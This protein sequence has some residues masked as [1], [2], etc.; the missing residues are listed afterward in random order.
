[1]KRHIPSCN[2]IFGLA[3][4]GLLLALPTRVSSWF[5]GLPWV[6]EAETILL[7]II[8]PFLLI[9]GWRFLAMRLPIILLSLLLLIKVMM[10]LTNPNSGWKIKVHPNLTQEQVKVG[11]F[12]PFEL[13]GSWVRTYATFWNENTSGILKMPW[14]EKLD[15]PLDWA[16][17]KN[18]NKCGSPPLACFNAL[19]PVIEFDGALLLSGNRKF[20]LIAEGVEDGR[21]SATNES[22]ETFQLSSAKTFMEARQSQYQLPKGRIW[23]I[24][25]KFEFQGKVWSLIPV[26]IEADGKVT[27]DLGRGVLWQSEDALSHSISYIGFY[28]T[29]SLI[30]DNGIVLFFLIWIGW[31]TSNLVRKDILNFP[32]AVCSI[33]AV[34]LPSIAAPFYAYIFKTIRINVPSDI[35]YLGFSIT[36]AGLGFLFWAWW[37]KDFRNFQADR[38]VKS[39]FLL[40]GPAL[41][42]YFSKRWYKSLGQWEMWTAGDDWTTYQMFARRIVIDG[43]WLLA[44]EERV[45]VYQPLYRYFI[46]TYHLLFGQSYFVQHM[47]DVWCI[48]GVVTLCSSL[49]LKFRLTTPIVYI[50]SIAYLMPT[51]IGAFRYR[52]GVGLAEHHA[53][54]FM[55]LT[56]WLLC[57]SRGEGYRKVI[58]A[59]LFGVF[60]YWM[61]QDHIFAIAALV[62]LIVE[63][64]GGSVGELWR[65]YW[66][67]IRIHWKQGFT[68]IGILSFGIFLVCFRNWWVGGVFSPTYLTHPSVSTLDNWESLYHILTASPWPGLPQITAAILL[69]GTLLGILSL[70]WRPDFLRQYPASLGLVLIGCVLPYFFLRLTG[71]TPRFSIHLLPFATLSV[72][73]GLDSLCSRSKLMK[74]LKLKTTPSSSQ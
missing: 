62:F 26:L 8:I 49:A 74:H 41:L 31:T 73:I 59:G 35:T 70:V 27:S 15:F 67:K 44:G 4:L 23:K 3:A 21:L 25:G 12:Y 11:A 24:S 33:L 69:P 45:F 39:V 72:I 16:L 53:I 56:G 19:N 36:A 38:V 14:L 42:F 37:K 20:A 7:A 58:L 61:R 13:E 34:C 63:P 46:S 52:I 2:F 43:Q 6:G 10:F 9:L 51:L 29:L 57:Q 1:M 65:D 28:R 22:G 68:Y 47:A 17:Y 5:D 71:Y 18:S 60:G 64:V 30:T 40:F 48:L 54:F 50:A 32:F 66:K 55:I